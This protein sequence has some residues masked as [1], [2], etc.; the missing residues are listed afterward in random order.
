MGESFA[1]P[2]RIKSSSGLGATSLPGIPMPPWPGWRINPTRSSSTA[3][4][5]FLQ[6]L[7]TDDYAKALLLAGALQ[8]DRRRVQVY[9]AVG[10]NWIVRDP[11]GARNWMARVNLPAEIE[12]RIRA[13]APLENDGQGDPER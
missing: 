2:R 7:A 3:Y 10:R 4:A 11:D 6:R 8:D 5:L 1:L 12:K 13:P 9:Q